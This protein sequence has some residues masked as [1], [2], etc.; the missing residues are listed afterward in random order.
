MHFNKINQTILYFIIILLMNERD[1]HR[2]TLKFLEI[3]SCSTLIIFINSKTL[4]SKTLKKILS[5]HIQH[6]CLFLS[7]NNEMILHALHSRVYEY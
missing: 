5:I 3:Q 2:F 1:L 6:L 4:N 7:K